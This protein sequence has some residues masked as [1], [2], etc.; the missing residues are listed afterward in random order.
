M[1]KRNLSWIDSKGNEH[2]ISQKNNLVLLKGLQGFYMPPVAI[3]EE[4]VPFQSGSRHRQTQIKAREIDVPLKISGADPIEF[5]KTLR[6]LL[7]TFNPLKADGKF[8]VTG[9]D[10][11]QRELSCRYVHGFE[12]DESQGMKGR[13]WQKAVGVFRAF[14]PFWYD[15]NTI[16][17]TF[18]INESSG[19]FF[20]ILP[21]RLASSTVFADISIDN[22]GDVETWPEWIITGPGENIALHNL[23]TGEII[24]L[25]VSLEA[26]ETITIDA[27]PFHKTISKNDG[28]NLFYTLSDD[29]ALWSLQDGD[30][31]IQI[32]MANATT[33]SSIQL[34]YRNRYWGP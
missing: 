9:F 13:T 15:S 14:D 19:L 22:T 23:S 24:R 26:G 17:Q 28:T 2:E 8:K 12:M 31:S 10:N 30:N 5:E 33:E 29:S 20:P 25:D 32:E 16:V 1:T 18:K 11:R 7:R 6:W 3:T 4:E 34:T 21:L 27:K